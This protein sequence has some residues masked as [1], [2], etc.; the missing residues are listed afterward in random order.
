MEAKREHLVRQLHLAAYL[1]IKG[2]KMVRLDPVPGHRG[3]VTFVFQNDPQINR[4]RADY[5]DEAES[6]Y[7][8]ARQFSVVLASVKKQ[9]M[10]AKG[11]MKDNGPEDDHLW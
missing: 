8:P 10:S 1:L 4:D 3:F 9:A 11:E 5:F 6:S 2:H 7:V